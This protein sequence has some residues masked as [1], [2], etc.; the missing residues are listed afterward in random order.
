MF[1]LGVTDT[2]KKGKLAAWSSVSGIDYIRNLGEATYNAGYILN[3]S[4]L[5]ISFVT[6]SIQTNIYYT[7]DHKV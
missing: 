5:N 3:L 6:T 2:N 1:K 4:F 7:L